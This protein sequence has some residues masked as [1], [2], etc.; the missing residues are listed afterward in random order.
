LDDRRLHIAL[1]VAAEDLGKTF[2]ELRGGFSADKTASAAYPMLKKL[3]GESSSYGTATDIHKKLRA[4]RE[5]LTACL[6]PDGNAHITDDMVERHGCDILES[7]PKTR[8]EHPTLGLMPEDFWMA[9]NFELWCEGWIGGS[10]KR[11]KSVIG[12]LGWGML[13][14]YL[15]E[16]IVPQVMEDGAMIRWLLHIARDLRA[17]RM[18]P[19]A[20]WDHDQHFD[21]TVPELVPPEAS[22]QMIGRGSN[23]ALSAHDGASLPALLSVRAVKQHGQVQPKPELT[24]AGPSGAPKASAAGPTTRS[25]QLDP[26]SQG[27]PMAE[28]DVKGLG[29]HENNK[30]IEEYNVVPPTNPRDYSVGPGEVDDEDESNREDVMEERQL[31]SIDQSDD[32][33]EAFELIR[34]FVPEHVIGLWGASPRYPQHYWGMQLSRRGSATVLSKATRLRCK[35]II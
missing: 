34:C 24:A 11:R 13:S 20:W 31:M 28:R 21:D 15:Q 30:G 16:K 6:N 25:L 23:V 14:C 17:I 32:M 1:C 12:C 22:F 27:Q 8:R 10:D 2:V 35:I 18:Q 29:D 4:A 26:K 7:I 19:P 9:H 5:K 33:V 3:V